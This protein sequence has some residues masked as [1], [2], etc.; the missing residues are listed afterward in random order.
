MVTIT[1]TAVLLLCCFSA[2]TDSFDRR[3]LAIIETH[4]SRVTS[5]LKILLIYNY[6][7]DLP[8]T[9]D[10]LAGIQTQDPRL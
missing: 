3:N 8:G 1:S 10:S 5:Q 4:N 9:S 6:T 7:A 2:V